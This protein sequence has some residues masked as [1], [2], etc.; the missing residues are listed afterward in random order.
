VKTC[1]TLFRLWQTPPRA[2]PIPLPRTEDIQ[3]HET[4]DEPSIHS[5]NKLQLYSCK[6]YGISVIISC[7]VQLLNFTCIDFISV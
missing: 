7:I 2:Q 6:F 4:I 5:H 3:G 1:E